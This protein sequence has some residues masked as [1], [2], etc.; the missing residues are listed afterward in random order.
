M[1]TIIR[2]EDEN[3]GDKNNVLN[4]VIKTST[5]AFEINYYFN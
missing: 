5:A 1:L 4:K 3:R 2:G